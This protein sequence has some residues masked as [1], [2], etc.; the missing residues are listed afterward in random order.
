MS[1][2][3]Q[4]VLVGQLL[5]EQTRFYLNELANLCQTTPDVIIEMVDYGVI[6]A[7]GRFPEEWQFSGHTVVKIHKAL[8][9]IHDLEVNL[10]GVALILSMLDE[11]EELR[12][13]LSN[14]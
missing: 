2:Q 4:D 14:H 6:E 11:L 3:K 1:R 5:D 12:H 9:L 8:N 10:A 7:E 13:R